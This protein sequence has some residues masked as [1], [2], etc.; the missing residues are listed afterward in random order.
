MSSQT[1]LSGGDKWFSYSGQI[2]GDVSSPATIQM[3]LIPNTGLR[4]SLVQFQ[5]Y[6]G[7]RV[8]GSGGQNLGYQVK[9]DDVV[10]IDSQSIYGTDDPVT[11]GSWQSLFIPRQSKL[12]VISL[13]TSGNNTQIRGCNITGYYL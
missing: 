5:P 13:N 3:I 12:E 1:L 8:S 9:L 7:K 11:N 2:F 10:I 4:D 6:Y